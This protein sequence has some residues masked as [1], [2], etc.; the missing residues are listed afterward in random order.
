MNKILA[1]AVNYGKQYLRTKSAA[2]FTFVFPIVLVLVFGAIFSGGT[3]KLD[4]PVQNLDSGPSGVAYLQVLN[5]T[6]GVNVKMIPND[7]DLEK[8][9]KDNSLSIAVQIPREFS[10]SLNASLANNGSGFVNITVYGDPTQSTFGSV[11]AS[12]QTAEA[13][14]NY[15]FAEAK[16]ILIVDVQSVASESFEEMD[17][18][19]PGVVGITIMTNAL[20]GMTSVCAEYKSRGYSKLLAT[21][22]LTKSEWL[23]SKVLTYTVLL[24]AS[25]VVTYLVGVLVLGLHVSLTPL[26]FVLIP[27]GAFLFTSA[28]M[29]LG[30]VTKD[31]ESAAAI[32]NAIGFPMMFLSGSFFPL[33]M[34]PGFL[35]TVAK[36]IPMTY[37]TNAM[38]DT[39]LFGNTTSALGNLA[40]LL[41]LGALLFVAGSK[42][43][44]WKD[45]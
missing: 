3:T 41:V 12:V 13:I 45:K 15:H 37:L 32:A 39:M 27:A 21:T 5:E 1:D 4:V 19:L 42:L 31:A 28:G 30:S 34:M 8:Y 29:A 38:R 26:V 11:M 40:I 25:V 44:S 18:F 9:I 14:M 24:S 43:M 36:G 2:F 22:T 6:G 16:P 17:Y 35:Q 7:V 33:D 20:F 10:Q 23:A